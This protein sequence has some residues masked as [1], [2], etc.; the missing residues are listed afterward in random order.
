LIDTDT[1]DHTNTDWANLI[2]TTEP[3]LLIRNHTTYAPRLTPVSPLLALP[4]GESGWALTAG[5]SGTL[6]DLTIRPYPPAQAPLQ[7][8]Q[9]RVA[10]SAVGVNFRD[11]L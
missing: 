3:Q 11:V 10:V 5:G 1:T 4:A 9:L 2:N 7:A 6:Q 8:G